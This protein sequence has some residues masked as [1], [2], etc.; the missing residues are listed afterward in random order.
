MDSL[1]LKP[2]IALTVICIY[3]VKEFKGQ[4]NNSLLHYH[5]G[6]KPSFIASDWHRQQ[7]PKIWAPAQL[8][9][10]SGCDK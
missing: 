7:S 10:A 9:C 3:C 5:L 1:S 2:V 4:R 6:T 8:N